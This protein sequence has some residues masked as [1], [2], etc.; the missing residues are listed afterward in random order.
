[1]ATWEVQSFSAIKLETALHHVFE[2]RQFQIE[3]PTVT[4]GFETPKEWYLV[5]SERDSRKG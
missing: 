5:N 4:G 2:D 3:V 1:M